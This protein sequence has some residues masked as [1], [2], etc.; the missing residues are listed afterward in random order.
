[1][2]KY[3]KA[4][5]SLSL[6]HTY[7]YTYLGIRQVLNVSVLVARRTILGIVIIPDRGVIEGD[8]E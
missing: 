7:S 8:I 1:M 6:T 4:T 5:N 3:V 2:G